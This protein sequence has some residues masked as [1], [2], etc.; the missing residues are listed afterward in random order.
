M[1]L[2]FISKNKRKLFLSTNDPD[3][4]AIVLKKLGKLNEQI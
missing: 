1:G 2:H 4:L 3:T